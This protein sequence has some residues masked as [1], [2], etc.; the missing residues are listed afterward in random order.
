ME[1]INEKQT[2]LVFNNL[3][4]KI[5]TLCSSL[6]EI[7]FLVEFFT[8]INEGLFFLDNHTDTVF[9]VMVNTHLQDHENK[10]LYLR[11]GT[12]LLQEITD[13]YPFV[14]TKI[15]FTI[16][17]TPI[18][19]DVQTALR[20]NS[21]AIGIPLDNQSENLPTILDLILNNNYRIFSPIFSS[22]GELALEIINPLGE[23]EYYV[24]SLLSEKYSL[25]EI[26]NVFEMTISESMVEN[27]VHGISVKLQAEIPGIN[28]LSSNQQQN[29]IIRWYKNE[30]I[31][32]FGIARKVPYKPVDLL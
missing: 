21:S 5:N 11:I 1:I 27:L 22:L 24:V 28:N 19:G 9:G 18:I 30:A 8:N 29:Q 12:N 23:V 7:G 2:I 31:H 16:T 10:N 32:K 4:T 15:L 20:T 3:G 6:E 17:N 26:G 25:S 13:K 14:A